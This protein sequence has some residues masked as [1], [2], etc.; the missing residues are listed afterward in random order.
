MINK[1]ESP[2]VRDPFDPE[3][4]TDGGVCDSKRQPIA[5]RGCRIIFAI[6]D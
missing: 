6:S 3:Q 5:D 2:G 1:A 4:N